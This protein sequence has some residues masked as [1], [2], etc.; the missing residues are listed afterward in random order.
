MKVIAQSYT[1]IAQTYS[2]KEGKASVRLTDASGA[3][4]KIS[5]DKNGYQTLL[6]SSD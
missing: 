6:R 3:K 5:V 1:S 2:D 4:L